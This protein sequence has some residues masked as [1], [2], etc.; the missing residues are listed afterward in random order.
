MESLNLLKQEINQT[1]ESEHDFAKWKLIV[2]AALGGAA[3]GL[4]KTDLAQP[5]LI[6]FIPFACAYID[7]H[8]SQYQARMLVLAHF[9]RCYR[10]GSA[11]QDK[12]E[13]L[14]R[15]EDY[16]NRL[17]KSK[18]HI[19]DLGQLASLIA[20]LGLSISAPGLAFAVSW[21]TPQTFNFHPWEWGVWFAGIVTICVV[22][23]GNDRRQKHLKVESQKILKELFHD[24]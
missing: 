3:L 15:Y 9:I 21:K 2:V 19:F 24:R 10:F 8:L 16:C 22:W 1:I 17:R 23:I 7:L 20:S 5:W 13:T 11:A 18:R 4:N 6:L 14:P 12:D